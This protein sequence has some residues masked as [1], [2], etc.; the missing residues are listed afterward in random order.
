MELSIDTSTRYASIAISC[1]GIILREL[2]W[3]SKRNH[4]VELVPAI[5]TLLNL[6]GMV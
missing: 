4:S 1:E 2:S 5:T 6:Q 3:S